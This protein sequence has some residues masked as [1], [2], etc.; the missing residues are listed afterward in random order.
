MS[1][2]KTFAANFLWWAFFATV[3]K[4]HSQT[5]KP[6][7]LRFASSITRL[8]LWGSQPTNWNLNR[9]HLQVVEKV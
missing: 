7:L 2:K 9:C 6:R 4:E 3:Q 8:H 1:R 5:R